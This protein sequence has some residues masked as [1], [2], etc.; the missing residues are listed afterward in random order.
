MSFKSSKLED[1][2]DIIDSHHQTPKYSKFGIAMVRGTDVKYG[3][4]SLEDTFKVDAST[5]A[6][7]SRRYK[8]SV[9]DIIITRVGTYGV[10]GRVKNIDFCLGQ[11]TTAIVPKKINPRYLYAVLNTNILREQIEAGTVGST[12]RTLSLKNIKSLEIPRFED[13][14]EKAIARTLGAID[15][16]IILLQEI[17]KNIENITDAIYKCWFID[18]DL[19]V[20]L[21]DHP[22]TAINRKCLANIF[23][24]ER[25]SSELGDIPVG[26]EVKCATDVFKFQKGCEPGTKNYSTQKIGDMLPF[27]RVGDLSKQNS[28]IFIDSSYFQKGGVNE[29]DILLSTD[30]SIGLVAYG[31]KGVISGGIRR[32]TYLNGGSGLF[33][34]H[35]LKGKQFQNELDIN[36]PPQTTIRHAGTG[37]PKI[38]LLSPPQEVIDCFDELTDCFFKKLVSNLNEIEFLINLRNTI[39]SRLISGKL[40]IHPLDIDIE[41]SLT[42]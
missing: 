21:R 19:A 10:T 8:P 28:N 26:W 38:R 29:S 25:I 13:S 22:I 9:N 6:E 18:F 40:Q 24:K 35:T 17:N 7:F 31:Y 30:G 27:I 23:S 2:A 34:Y 15:D 20:Q 33:I 36:T 41:T 39:S 32:V 11:N 1:V 16:K 37:L 42:D 4:I 5:Y 14:K 12:Q 3:V